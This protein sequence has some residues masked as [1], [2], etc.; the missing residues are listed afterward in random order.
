MG[1]AIFTTLL[2]QC[3]V[4]INV[5]QFGKYKIFLLEVGCWL[6]ILYRLHFL[7]MVGG[8]CMLVQQLHSD[9]ARTTI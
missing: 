8:G 7:N 5:L 4:P 9:E 3:C 1:E 2:H 6:L